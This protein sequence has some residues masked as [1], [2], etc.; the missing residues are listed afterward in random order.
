MLRPGSHH[1]VL[2]RD[3]FGFVVSSTGVERPNAP[4]H[5]VTWSLQADMAAQVGDDE[6]ERPVCGHPPTGT[7]AVGSMQTLASQ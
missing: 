4:V 2:I 5:R 7:T 1:H 3:T 6:H